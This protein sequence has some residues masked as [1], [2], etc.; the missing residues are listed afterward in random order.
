MKTLLLLLLERSRNVVPA[1]IT[2]SAA[3]LAA[4]AACGLAEEGNAIAPI[5]AIA[6]ALRGEEAF[7]EEAGACTPRTLLRYT[8]PAVAFSTLAMGGWGLIHEF[9]SARARGGGLARSLASGAGVSLLA[10]VI[11][12]KVVGPRWTPGIEARLSKRSV[13]LAYIALALGLALAPGRRE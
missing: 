2:A 8:L 11:D 12:Y 3:T 7:G 9:T 5:N 10:Y 1:A 4:S 6:H 13:K